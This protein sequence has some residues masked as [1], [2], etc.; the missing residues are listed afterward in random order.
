MQVY[1]HLWPF[2]FIGHAKD[3][4]YFLVLRLESMSGSGTTLH[5]VAA[6]KITHR[7][8]FIIACSRH[9]YMGVVL[10]AHPVRGELH[11]KDKSTERLQLLQQG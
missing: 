10:H 6:R 7:A 4:K 8:H 2:S 1:V 11:I 5:T 3:K 9:I